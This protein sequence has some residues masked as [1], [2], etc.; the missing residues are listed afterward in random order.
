LPVWRFLDGARAALLFF[1]LRP[2][3][4]VSSFSLS[5]VGYF[6]RWRHYRF[7]PP[8]NLGFF[9]VLPRTHCPPPRVFPP[10][11]APIFPLLLL[12]KVSKIFLL[13]SRTDDMAFLRLW[14]LT[15]R[16]PQPVLRWSSLRPFARLLLRCFVLIIFL[17]CRPALQSTPARRDC[18]RCL[19]S[20]FALRSDL[21]CRVASLL[22]FLGATRAPL[23]NFLRLTIRCTMVAPFMC[24]YRRSSIFPC[25]RTR[26]WAASPGLRFCCGHR[27]P[28][29]ASVCR[30]S[31]Q[32]PNVDLVRSPV[33]LFFCDCAFF[34]RR[35]SCLSGLTPIFAGSAWFFHSVADAFRRNRSTF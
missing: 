5:V 17:R 28:I 32:L 16:L 8:S 34:R 23:R 26:R 20:L 15:V 14:F 30:A 3:F 22:F 4:G 11:H 7:F 9:P 10:P 25:R 19:L 24:L 27:S 18:H 33:Y 13:F 12:G 35:G 21:L 6:E 29:L 2:L 31:T 1:C